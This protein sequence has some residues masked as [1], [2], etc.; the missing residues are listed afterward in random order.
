MKRTMPTDGTPAAWPVYL[1]ILCLALSA[2]ASR[3]RAE[4][5]LLGFANGPIVRLEAER[6]VTVADD[7]RAPLQR[8]NV[9]H[10]YGVVPAQIANAWV[11]DRIALS[12]TGGAVKL[13]ILDASVVL[14]P[15]PVSGGLFGLFRN[16][17]DRRLTGTLAV[18][19]DYVGVAG[20]AA[21]A[22]ASVTVTR[23]IREKADADEVEAIYFDMIRV[24]ADGFDETMTQKIRQSFQRA[25]G[26]AA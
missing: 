16:E 3:D 26:G 5:P 9:E 14:E 11:R 12:G 23:T 4:P 20:R 13:T 15:V 8:P 17:I 19:L 21:S 10:E 25:S 24:M 2:C 22:R 18:Q 6:P 1:I 7:Y